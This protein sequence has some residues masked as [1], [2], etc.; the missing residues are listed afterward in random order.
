MTELFFKNLEDVKLFNKMGAKYNLKTKLWDLP[1]GKE[2]F[3]D[4]YKRVYFEIP[5]EDYKTV[6]NLGAIRYDKSIFNRNIFYTAKKDA[7]IFDEWINLKNKI[8]LEI[9]SDLYYD[10]KILGLKW[11]CHK[12][13]NYVTKYIEGIDDFIVTV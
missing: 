8:Y 12:G 2:E 4:D 6:S 13:L 7:L 10:L 9:P 11:D 3:F 1:E 5:S